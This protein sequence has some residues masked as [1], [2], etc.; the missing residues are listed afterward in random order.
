MFYFR[1][2]SNLEEQPLL[3]AAPHSGDHDSAFTVFITLALHNAH[4]PVLTAEYKNTL[5]G[6]S[7]MSTAVHVQVDA[8]MRLTSLMYDS[9]VCR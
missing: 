5:L 7:Q 6:F 3:S 9:G 8:M 1:L 2:K 4:Q